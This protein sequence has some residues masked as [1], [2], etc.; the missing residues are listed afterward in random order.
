MLECEPHDSSKTDL[1]LRAHAHRNTHH[2]ELTCTAGGIHSKLLI[3]LSRALKSEVG[4][5][6]GEQGWLQ[7]QGPFRFEGI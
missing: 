5:G 4:G 3:Q 7:E 6:G 2:Q 1:G